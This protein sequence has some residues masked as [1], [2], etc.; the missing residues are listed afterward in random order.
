MASSTL[1]A[2]NPATCPVT[3]G[4]AL[5][6]AIGQRDGDLLPDQPGPT[7][8]LATTMFPRAVLVLSAFCLPVSAPGTVYRSGRV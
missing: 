7:S 4:W 1:T 8:V 2:R 3:N 5:P 6:E